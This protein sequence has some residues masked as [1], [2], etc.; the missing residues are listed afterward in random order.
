V[1]VLWLGVIPP[2]AAKLAIVLGVVCADPIIL[3]LRADT[4]L[5]LSVDGPNPPFLTKGP[6]I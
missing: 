1:L 4:L 3:C 6:E 2:T 5:S